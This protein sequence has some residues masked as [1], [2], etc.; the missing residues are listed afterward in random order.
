[1]ATGLASAFV[2]LSILL[3]G[4]LATAADREHQVKSAFIYN[5][6]KFIDWPG[7]LGAPGSPF[8]IGVYGTSSYG[9]EI[10]QALSGKAVSG[11]PISIEEI[12][13]DSGARHCRLLITGATTQ[14]R[15][16]QI[17]K[18]CRGYGTVLVGESPD[19]VECGGTIGLTIDGG[20]VRFDVN[21]QTARADNIM[22]SSKLLSLARTVIH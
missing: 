4:S 20:R 9:P 5:F 14:D 10:E 8:V 15:I 2:C 7:G 17:L 6:A 22:I 11:H 13:S 16:A 19:F 21:M 3:T 18:A 12:R 1:M